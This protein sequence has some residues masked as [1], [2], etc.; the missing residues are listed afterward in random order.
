MNEPFTFRAG[1][2]SAPGAGTG[3]T[4]VGFAWFNFGS[5]QSATELTQVEC[6]SS[7]SGTM[8]ILLA[9]PSTSGGFDVS[10]IDSVSVVSGLNTFTVSGETLAQATIPPAGIVGFKSSVAIKF[11]DDSNAGAF[12]RNIS[13]GYMRPSASG[14][15]SGNVNGWVYT[16]SDEISFAWE[17]VTTRGG[18]SYVIDEDFSAGV[19]PTW[20]IH[21]GTDWTYAANEATPGATGITNRLAFYQSSNLNN[22][23]ISVEFQFEN[24]TGHIA[25]GKEPTLSAASIDYG[26]IV[27][28][29]I[30]TNEI[31]LHNPY[32]SG[33]TLPTV[34]HTD[35]VTMTLQTS[36]TYRVQLI[37]NGKEITVKLTD[38][39]D[40][41]TETFTYTV[42]N[43][44]GYAYGSP[45]VAQLDGSIT[46]SK[47][48]FYFGKTR[49]K[50]L[51][52]GDSI[53]EGSGADSNST[54]YA[55]QATTGNNLYAG[56]G[57]ITAVSCLRSFQQ[58]LLSLQPKYAVLYA[59]ANNSNSDTER[60]NYLVD[61]ELFWKRARQY[62][63]TPIVMLPTPYNDGT[64][65]TRI[66]AMRTA[67]IA[68]ITSDSMEVIRSDIALGGVDGDTY[69]SDLMADDVHPNQDGHDALFARIQS[70]QPGIL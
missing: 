20:G 6:Y 12:S 56:D 51:F 25:I 57:G 39:T 54:S 64:K 30:A 45:V 33:D 26:S 11:S 59:G 43:L 2:I 17:G 31:Y 36:R 10:E 24:S 49:P 23:T 1:T 46:V 66:D 58:D 63:V 47:V 5:S 27:S 7:G 70:D 34:R 15:P 42:S 8:E 40:E 4:S 29:D 44:Y 16:K 32:N 55:A 18:S 69:D 21:E 19:K 3:N 9:V 50:T 60:D 14:T 62:G 61:F 48:Q 52:Y 37:K 68:D 28:V 65:Q 53:T 13:P 38:M 41:T 22:Q 35:S 67:V